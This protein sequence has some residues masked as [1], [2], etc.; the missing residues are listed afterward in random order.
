MQ[1]KYNKSNMS[2]TKL[3]RILVIVASMAFLGCKK[4]QAHDLVIIG[5]QVYDVEIGEFK[6]QNIGVVD[7]RIVEISENSLVGTTVIDAKDQYV[8]P[9]FIDAHAHFVGYA[10]SLLSAD[11][12]GTSSFEEVVQRVV[13]FADRNPEIE[14]ITGRGWDQND[15]K[16]SEFPTNDTLNALFPDVPVLLTRIDGH[17]AL[18]NQAALRTLGELPSTTEGGKIIMANGRPTGMLIDNAVDLIKVPDLPKDKLAKALIK[19]Q[20]NCFAVGLTHVV[21]AGLTRQTILFLDSLQ[22]Q[23]VLKMPIYAMIKDDSVEY[24][25]FFK[26]GFLITDRLSVRS[27]KVYGDGALGSRGALLL[28]PYSDDPE[29]YGLMLKQYKDL[30]ELG[31]RALENGFQINVHAIGDSANRLVLQAMAEVLPEKNDARWRIEHAQVVNP[32]DSVYFQTYGIIPSVQP[33]H[34]TSDMYWAEE[35]LGPERIN[36][37]YAFRSLMKWNGQ[38]AL[39]TDFPVEHIDPRKTLYAATM[40]QDEEGYPSGGFIPVERLSREDALRGMTI[41]AAHAQFQEN[42]TGS[43]KVGKWADLIISTTN[44]LQCEDQELLSA[45]I[46]TTIIRGEVVYQS[47]R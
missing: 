27:I 23:T 37:A 6:S 40:R 47:V 32:E 45:P 28:K 20:A 5:A 29:N 22:K 26:E 42:E 39:G 14:F 15:W 17:A 18:A 8:Y 4:E 19:A 10:Q 11:L 46:N 9:G 33:T 21:D 2:L 35:R 34:A 38:V 1:K 3:L 12:I 41:W 24:N 30:V 13:E 44:L 36:H 7:G 25:S 43:I 16:K 31:K